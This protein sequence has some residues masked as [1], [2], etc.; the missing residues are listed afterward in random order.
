MAGLFV[1]G[2]QA[3]QVE[4]TDHQWE[5]DDDNREVLYPMSRLATI[6]G[7]GVK[8]KTPWR[9]RTGGCF[10]PTAYVGIHARYPMRAIRHGM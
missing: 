10:R 1:F 7:A 6:T 5:S 9:W 8:T 3:R 4:E 2:K